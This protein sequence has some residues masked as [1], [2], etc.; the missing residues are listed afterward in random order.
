MEVSEVSKNKKLLID[1]VPFNV[2]SVDFVKPGK[3]RAIYHLK[4]RNLLNGILSEPT[5]HSGDKFDEATITVRDMQYLY[6][7]HGHYHFMDT[8]SF[9]QHIMNEENVGDKKLYLKDSLG[10]QVM[11]WED[12]PIDLILPKAVELKI[13]ETESAMKGATVTAQQKLARL[14]TG[15][16]IGVP[17]FIKEGDTVRISTITGAYV[18]RVG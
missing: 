8:E 17:A 2:E 6:E 7:E 1:G 14:E 18:E 4:L 9:E 15:L 12:R 11:M 3:G 10:V 16:E 13:I 5:Y